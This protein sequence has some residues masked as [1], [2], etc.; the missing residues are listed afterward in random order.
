MASRYNITLPYHIQWVDKSWQEFD[1]RDWVEE[2]LSLEQQAI[3]RVE[4]NR[5]GFCCDHDSQYFAGNM[6]LPG[7]NSAL[8]KMVVVDICPPTPGD[9]WF[10]WFIQPQSGLCGMRV[11]QHLAG[12]QW[13]FA[14]QTF[15]T[16]PARYV[17][18]AGS[19]PGLKRME[20]FRSAGGLVQAAD[21]AAVQRFDDLFPPRPILYVGD[22]QERRKVLQAHARTLQACHLPPPCVITTDYPFWRKEPVEVVGTNALQQ[23]YH[24]LVMVDNLAHFIGR[25]PAL[26]SEISHLVNSAQSSGRMLNLIVS[27]QHM[28]RNTMWGHIESV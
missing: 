27:S 12:E 7:D 9:W 18:Y 5:G 24:R 26:E 23:A 15:G 2:R 1:L 16:L 14:D 28:V 3:E 21:I 17:L 22:A 10:V 11:V 25:K 6:A 8:G 4:S 19:V 20:L 13:L